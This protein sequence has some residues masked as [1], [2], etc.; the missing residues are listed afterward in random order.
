MVNIRT[1]TSSHGDA[2]KAD[3]NDPSDEGGGS[4]DS[5]ACDVRTR[6]SEHQLGPML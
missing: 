2:K 4:G 6:L 1:V 3:N 5:K